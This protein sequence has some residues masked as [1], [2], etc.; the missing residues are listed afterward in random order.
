MEFE[1]SNAAVCICIENKEH[2]TSFI[3][4][5]QVKFEKFEVI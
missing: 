5:M 1:C 4:I 3:H 2:H